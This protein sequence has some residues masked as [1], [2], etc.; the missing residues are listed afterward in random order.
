MAAQPARRQHASVSGARPPSAPPADGPGL[1]GPRPQ[2][3]RFALS[4]LA[5]A[6]LTLLPGVAGLPWP[7]RATAA[8]TALTAGCWLTGALPLPVASLL[9]ALLLPLLGAVPAGEVARSYF[10]DILLLFLGGFLLAFALERYGLHERFALAALRCFGMRP[11]RVVLGVILATGALSLFINNTSTA[12]LM[13]P[14]AQAVLAGCEAGLAAALGPPLLLGLA[15]ACSMGGVGTP[16]GTAPNIIFLGQYAAH[17]PAAPPIPF[18]LWVLGVLPFT[19]AF[20]LLCWLVLT[21][22]HGPLPT[23]PIWSDA[24]LAARRS[25]LGPLRPAQKRVLAVF[26]AVVFLWIFRQPVDLGFARLPGWELLLPESVAHGLSEATVALLGAIVLYL[27]PGDPGRGTLLQLE[28]L[29]RAPWDVLL[30]M[31]GGFA[32]ASAFDATGL[33]RAI[34]GGLQESIQ[35]LP[36][37]AAVALTAAIVAGLS[38]VASNTAAITLL[39]PLLFSAAEA[40]RVHPLLLA[41]PAT[42]A[43][44]NAF[45]LPAGTP[46]NAIIFATGRVRIGQ[47]AR[48]G[49]ILDL[50][51]VVLVTLFTLFWIAPLW[52]IDLHAMPD[53]ARPG[54]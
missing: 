5:A 9:P 15:Y 25:K 31:G 54:G 30:L 34:A 32:L 43:V 27:L 33:S 38:E 2:A 41:L 49:L 45:M 36:P 1:L 39:L 20:L 19:A 44:S 51:T 18:G 7:A 24:E 48:A 17:Y 26:A 3:L 53:W 12:L 28:D 23:Q 29:R 42:L 46:P 21:L 8:V 6:A 10:H 47:M 40:A 11:R 14:V 35:G 4:A 37:W 16:I 52:G 13:L 50:A 22:L